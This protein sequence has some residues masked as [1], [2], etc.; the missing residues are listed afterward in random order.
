MGGKKYRCLWPGCKKVFNTPVAVRLHRMK[1]H[2][3]DLLKR[4]AAKVDPPMQYR[5]SHQEGALVLEFNDL[6][7]C[8]QK[9]R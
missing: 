8:I 5:I 6:H 3:K 9:K 1:E 2:A 4:A 7:I